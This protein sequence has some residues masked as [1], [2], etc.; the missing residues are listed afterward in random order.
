MRR[1]QAKDF[2][3]VVGVEIEVS[4]P[5]QRRKEDS[6]GENGVCSGT[7][8]LAGATL[9]WTGGAQRGSA[10]CPGH[11][12]EHGGASGQGLLQYPLGQ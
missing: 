1:T 3:T 5:S 6:R 12:A 2:S 10:A 8:K 4:A 9:L 11:T 7:G